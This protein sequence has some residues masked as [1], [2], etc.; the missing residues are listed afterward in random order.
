MTDREL[1]GAEAQQALSEAV[2]RTLATKPGRASALV[3]AETGRAEIVSRLENL[4]KHFHGATRKLLEDAALA[5]SSSPVQPEH[6]RPAFSVCRCGHWHIP[7]HDADGRCLVCTNPEHRYEHY[8]WLHQLRSTLE[9]AAFR[10]QRLGQA[11]GQPFAAQPDP[12]TPSSVARGAGAD[13]LK[14][15]RLLAMPCEGTNE[16]SWRKCKRCTAIHGLEMRFSLTMRL[17]NAAIAALSSSLVQPEPAGPD[18]L[19]QAFEAGHYAWP[20]QDAPTRRA[21]FER[22]LASVAVQPDPDPCDAC[23]TETGVTGVTY[24]TVCAA[25]RQ[26]DPVTP[27]LLAACRHGSSS[28]RPHRRGAREDDERREEL[29]NGT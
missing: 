5:L 4:A 19:W 2:R 17:L 12:V 6:G 18:Q 25:I 3:P 10:A 15:L 26:P 16:H 7:D 9:S 20:C 23:G 27:K 13:A 29:S 11:L 24:C 21:L 1:T 28:P 8:E 14:L 22:W